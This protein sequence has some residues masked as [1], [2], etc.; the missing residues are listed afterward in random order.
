MTSKDTLNKATLKAVMEKTNPVL[1]KIP[2]IYKCQRIVGETSGKRR[3]ANKFLATEE[4]NPAFKK[5]LKNKVEFT[6]SGKVDGCC[7]YVKN[8][9][10]CKR[11]VPKK[12]PPP[13]W[14]QT[15][16]NTDINKKIT[17]TNTEGKGGVGQ[18][19]GF[20]PVSNKSKEDK[21]LRKVMVDEDTA[22]VLVL[23]NQKVV[24]KELSLD[25]LE[26]KTVE[27]LGPKTECN[28]HNFK[29]YVLYPHG[30]IPL[31]GY[32]EDF[33][34]EKFQKW[35]ETDEI[36]KKFEGVVVHFANGQLFKVHRLHM[37]LQWKNGGKLEGLFLVKSSDVDPD[38]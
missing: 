5:N 32:P 37:D 16:A 13:G 28:K 6:V 10:L 38:L 33:D 2:C 23:Q 17:G 26:G 35:F 15:E 8:G 24:V 31:S 18:K 1:G 22:R 25:A 29:N 14:F 4:L 34:L 12:D 21:H 7:G 3:G 20:V 9:K 30:L 27:F 11:L 36:T 19:I